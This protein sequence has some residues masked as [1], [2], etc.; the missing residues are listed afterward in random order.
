MAR[1]TLGRATVLTPSASLSHETCA[2]LQGALKEESDLQRHTVVLDCRHVKSFD[3]EALELLLDC[4]RNLQK[5][6]S[7]LMLCGLNDVC[8][9]ILMAT[10]LSYVFRIF[11]DSK[12]AAQSGDTW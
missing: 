11:E 7:K 9:D 5:S 2:P 12:Q 3:S 6:G 4:Q 8:S 10:R 1:T